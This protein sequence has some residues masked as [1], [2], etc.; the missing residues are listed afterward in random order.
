MLRGKANV[1]A[2]CKLDQAKDGRRKLYIVDGD[3]DIFRSKRKPRLRF[4]HRLRCYC[5]ENMLLSAPAMIT[6]GV[7]ANVKLD[8]LDVLPAIDYAGLLKSFEDLLKPLFIYYA[9][10]NKWESSI[11]TVGYLVYRMAKTDGKKYVL[12]ARLVL[13]RIRFLIKELLRTAS[14]GQI[15]RARKRIATD[16]TGMLATQIVSAKDYLL[17]IIYRNFKSTLGYRGTMEQF[18]TRLAAE[19]SLSLDPWFCRTIRWL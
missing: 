1:L 6:V 15:R 7:E 19:F 17:P 13:Q 5:V 18:K 3:L 10:A 12:D 2:A 11:Q 9:L 4:L 14:V 8:D 16:I